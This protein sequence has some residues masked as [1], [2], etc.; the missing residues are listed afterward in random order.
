MTTL[1]LISMFVGAV[2]LRRGGV[3]GGRDAIAPPDDARPSLRRL[4]AEQ[5][6]PHQ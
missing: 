6:L 5:L 3:V 2:A 1:L 4:H